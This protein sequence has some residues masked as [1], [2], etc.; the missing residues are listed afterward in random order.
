MLLTNIKQNFIF[1]PLNFVWENLVTAHV[2]VTY[3]SKYTALNGFN[4][5]EN[6]L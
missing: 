4:W 2:T 3:I 5:K 6:Y 1:A